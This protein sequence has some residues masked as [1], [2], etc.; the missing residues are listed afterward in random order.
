MQYTS[1]IM[2]STSV[3][4]FERDIVQIS[5]LLKE[6]GY[7]ICGPSMG[8]KLLRPAADDNASSQIPKERPYPTPICNVGFSY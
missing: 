4:G 5:A 7:N 6:M 3:Y 1:N 2:L 8:S